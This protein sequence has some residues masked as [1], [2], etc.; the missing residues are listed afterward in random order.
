MLNID[1]LIKSR[2][3][4]FQGIRSLE[5]DGKMYEKIYA[6]CL[7]EITGF[8]EENLDEDRVMALVFQIESMEKKDQTDQKVVEVLLEA[9]EEIPDYRFRL[10]H[11]LEYFLDD[12]LLNSVKLKTTS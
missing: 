10:Y 1:M 9:I 4:L 12:L 8:I 6:L 2:Y 3:R 5:E 7:P 11:R